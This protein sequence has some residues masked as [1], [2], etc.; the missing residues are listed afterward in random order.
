MKKA[1]IIAFLS[2]GLS[3]FI[4]LPAFAGDANYYRNLTFNSVLNC[5]TDKQI[6]AFWEGGNSTS[7][8]LDYGIICLENERKAK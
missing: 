3:S 5:S 7:Y 6:E 4:S 8:G 1:L 2:T